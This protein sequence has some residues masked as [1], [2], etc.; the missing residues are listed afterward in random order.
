VEPH[1]GW[2]VKETEKRFDAAP[3]KAPQYVKETECFLGWHA[4]LDRVFLEERDRKSA[5]QLIMAATLSMPGI[6]AA[7]AAAAVLASV[8]DTGQLP[9]IAD[10]DKE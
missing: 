10:A 3:G 5:P 6:G 9:G 8:V 4:T 7:D 1:A 2:Y